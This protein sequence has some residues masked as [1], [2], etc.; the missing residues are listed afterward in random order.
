MK[1]KPLPTDPIR[2]EEINSLFSGKTVDKVEIL[3]LNSWSFH[4][5]DG[6]Q[7]TIDTFA[8][9]HGFHGPDVIDD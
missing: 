1:L 7:V 8:M 6:S 3:G 4:F 5:T 2:R 9:G